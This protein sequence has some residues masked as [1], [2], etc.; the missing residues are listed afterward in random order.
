MLTTVL[1]GPVVQ[2]PW[3]PQAKGVRLRIQAPKSLER[4]RERVVCLFQLIKS[5][6]RKRFKSS[7]QVMDA[8]NSL[9]EAFRPKDHLR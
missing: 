4:E 6:A 3:R 8:I 7:G 1:G 5:H 9:C 2:L